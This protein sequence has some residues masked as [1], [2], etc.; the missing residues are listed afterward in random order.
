MKRRVRLWALVASVACLAAACTAVGERNAGPTPADNRPEDRASAE[1]PASDENLPRV[2]DIPEFVQ[3][4]IPLQ[5]EEERTASGQLAAARQ[6]IKRI[7]FIIKEN[8]T[9][10]HLF[11]RF[12]RGDGA[13]EGRTCD[14]DTVPLR[15]AKDSVADVAHSFVAG[16]TAVNGGANN[17][18]DRLLGGSELQ[19]YVQY[20]R[21]DIPN[22]WAYADEF[23]LADRFFSS[24]Y[25]PTG[26]EHLWTLA[27]Q[28][29]RLVD[30]Q[31]PEQSGKGAEREFCTDKLERAWA[32]RKMTKEERDQ[33]YELEERPAITELVRRFWEERWPCFDIPILPDLLEAKGVSWGYYTS[34][35]SHTKAIKMIRHIR[36]GPMWRK[37]QSSASFMRA[38]RSNSLPSVSWLVPPQPLSDHPGF[39]RPGMCAG[40]NW[41]VRVLNTLMRSK[42]WANTAVILTWDDFGGFY[43][44]VVPPHVDLY[45]YGPRVPTLV[46]SPWAKRSAIDSHTYDFSSVLKTIER[47]FG[48]GSLGARDARASDMLASFDF[49][50]TPID[51]LILEERDCPPAETE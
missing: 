42:A 31:R 35:G 20:E 40:E 9:Y 8:R 29:R 10:D 23:T 12:P 51:P 5:I 24:I 11:G 30:H 33:A 32:F 16:L 21:E 37:V 28:S 13:T 47:I 1:E 7:V 17:C 15:R 36:F 41:T 18:F 6:K 45:G 44:H 46:I 3:Q 43:D 4:H 38:A 22:Y 26:V 19:G 50:Q 25:G 49:D 34:G 48:L 2:R 39:D 14:G 27:G